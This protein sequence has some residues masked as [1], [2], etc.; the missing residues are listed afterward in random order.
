[1]KKVALIND[2]S[3]F[4]K[5]SLTA[6][7]PVISV[8]GLQACPLP[9][10]ILSAQTGFPS[11][12]CDDY[13]EKMDYFTAEWKKMNVHFDGIHSGYL[14][15]PSQIAK[16]MSFLDSFQKQESV[17]LA[18]P[19]LGDNGKTFKAFSPALLAGMKQLV[20][21]ASVTTPNLTELCLLTEYD[22]NE[23]ITHAAKSDY[24]ERIAAIC[25]TLLEN[26]ATK[27][28]I[29]VTG[30]ISYTNGGSYMGNLSVNANT[31]FYTE[32]P[33]T[34]IGFSGTGDLF[35]AVVCGGL[36]NGLPLEYTIR[37][38]ADFLQPAIEEASQKQ[39]PA[40][41]GIHFEKYLSK[42]MQL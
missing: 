7:I 19:V 21:R 12:Y 31:T 16:V 20:S 5:C 23:L 3:G 10:A 38:A 24:L 13:T 41:H 37:L 22:Y 4:G 35:A 1:M 17:Y 9:T 32:T 34:G 15:S 42:L 28:T 27:Q 6:A 14:A 40:A 36:V 33:Y 18:D 30:I 25:H 8:M 26:A 2:L 29:I 39:V 11:F